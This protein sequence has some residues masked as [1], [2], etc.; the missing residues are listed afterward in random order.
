MS[1]DAL[2]R[3]HKAAFTSGRP[4]SAQEFAALCAE[5]HTYLTHDTYGFAL[6]RA[7]AGE[8]ELLTIAVDPAHQGRG[9]GRALMRAWM[10]QAASRADTA[11]LEVAAD[12]A[13]ACALYATCGFVTVATRPGYYARPAGAADARVMR[14]PLTDDKH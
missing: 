12:N 1:P 11:F 5:P 9:R 13:P 6:W 10:A 8:A 4:W 3:L 7:A 2:A 14:A